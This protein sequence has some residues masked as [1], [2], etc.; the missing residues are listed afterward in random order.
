MAYTL[1]LHRDIEKQLSRI[2]KKQ[3][4]RLVE[5]MRS[6]SVEARPH[7]CQYLQDE[8]YRIREG[9]YRIIYAIFDDEVVIVVCKV[10]RRTEKT[11]KDLEGLL[12]RALRELLK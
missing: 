6:L 12:D 3:R 10:T 7:G 2:P 8:L 9:Q 5:A 4:E 1:K 11:Y